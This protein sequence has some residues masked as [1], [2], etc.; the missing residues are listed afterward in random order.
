MCSGAHQSFDAQHISD[1]NVSS[2]IEGS[3]SMLRRNIACQF[4]AML[5]TAIQ[6][7]VDGQFAFSDDF[8]PD[9]RCALLVVPIRTN[10][11]DGRFLE[12]KFKATE[13]DGMQAIRLQRGDDR[14]AIPRAIT[15]VIALH[16]QIY[17]VLCKMPGFRLAIDW[18]RRMQFMLVDDDGGHGGDDD[19]FPSS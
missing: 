8:D 17:A 2:C 18:P 11:K 13:Y 14:D 4:G 10:T 1:I 19:R 7:G 15:S 3:R 6:R 9:L 5:S 16:R 12:S